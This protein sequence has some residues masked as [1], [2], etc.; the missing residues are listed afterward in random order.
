MEL[1]VALVAFVALDAFALWYGF[2]SRPLPRP[3]N[4]PRSEV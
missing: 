1:V 2:D 3:K 4:D